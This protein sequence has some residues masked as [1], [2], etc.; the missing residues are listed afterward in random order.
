MLAGGIAYGACF[1]LVMVVLPLVE[2]EALA[3][4]AG[5]V[6]SGLM[7]LVAC[8]V[9]VLMRIRGLAAFGVRRAKPRH[10]IVGLLLGIGAYV[11]SAAVSLAVFVIG[12]E[13]Q[14]VQ[15]SYQA[16]AAGGALSLAVT[17]V[18]GSVLTPIG[19][20]AFFRGVVANAL[21]ARYR[22]W[23]AIVASAAVFALAHGINP[24]LPVAF[25]VGV[26][27]AVLFHRSGSIWPGVAL[28]AGNNAMA[29]LVPVVIAAALPQ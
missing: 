12:G 1:L 26:L 13:V 10:L 27:A 16:A 2:D 5:F 22:A 29:T 23:I 20:E 11:V 7:G 21:F 24:I 8:A 15:T 18:A 19:E 17:L 6:A 3:G 4:V 28:H 25:L 14:N 9:A